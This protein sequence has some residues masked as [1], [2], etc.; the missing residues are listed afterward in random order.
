MADR[1]VPETARQQDLNLDAS[2]RLSIAVPMADWR[3]ER[4]PWPAWRDLLHAA[5]ILALSAFL[6]AHL[7]LA[8]SIL[9][10]NEAL[11]ASA[12][13]FAGMRPLG[14][15]SPLVVSL[16]VCAV[17]T[18]FILHAWLA[19]RKFP[20]GYRQERSL[21]ALPPRRQDAETS[22]W[23]LQ[24]GTGFALF[25]MA[26]FHLYAMLGQPGPE[27]AVSLRNGG[28]WPLYLMLLFA[29]ELHAGIA[30]YRLSSARGWFSATTDDR[31]RRRR[32]RARSAL[33]AFFIA[34]GLLSS[35]AYRQLEHS[36]SE[37]TAIR[38]MPG[39]PWA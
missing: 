37:N 4:R 12:R 11:A 39:K 7:L 9:S 38:Q 23:W 18:I 35:L 10:S 32:Q 31:D 28:M 17:T 36:H 2:G 8:V 24:T 3:T 20:A 29:A 30:L 13:L 25:C 1:T 16:V 34:L 19:M 14:R 6:G 27:A 22:L 5:C 21:A 15:P 33:S 26:T